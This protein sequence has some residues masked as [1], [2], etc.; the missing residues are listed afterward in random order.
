MRRYAGQTSTSNN[1]SATMWRMYFA[2]L[3]VV[4]SLEKSSHTIYSSHFSTLASHT[5]AGKLQSLL[6]KEE[7]KR[8]MPS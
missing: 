1:L 5:L 6:V 4:Q 8:Q 2:T 3:E 7:E